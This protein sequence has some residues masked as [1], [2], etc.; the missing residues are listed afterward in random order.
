LNY[1][2]L[3]YLYYRKANYNQVI[4]SL[5]KIYLHEFYEKADVSLKVPLS[6]LELIARIDMNDYDSFEYKLPQIKSSFKNEWKNFEGSEKQILP[7]IESIGTDPEYLKN[8]K[9]KE[10]AR[11]FIAS[12]IGITELF[13]Y[14]GWL[15]SRLKLDY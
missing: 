5:Q 13:N 11:E 14:N 2:N 12:G 6:V 7:L 10:K 3:A 15:T 8:K 9:L 4:K 1:S